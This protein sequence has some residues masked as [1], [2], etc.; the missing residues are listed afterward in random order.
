MYPTALGDMEGSTHDHR[1]AVWGPWCAATAGNR[2]QYRRGCLHGGPSASVLV[3]WSSSRQHLASRQS[4][5]GGGSTRWCSSRSRVRSRVALALSGSSGPWGV[6]LDGAWLCG[7]ARRYLRH[8][9]GT[10][11]PELAGLLIAD[12]C[13]AG[14]AA[15][16]VVTSEDL[17]GPP[18][19][20][21]TWPGV[22]LVEGQTPRAGGQVDRGSVVRIRFRHVGGDEGGVRAPR[23]SSP[24]LGALSAEQPPPER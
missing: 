3:T 10:V 13:E 5:C 21:L 23:S 7:A 4:S 16:L 9:T 1:S 20:V 18:L 2:C 17:D 24:D 8:V 6:R 14:Q 12:A 19:A 15:G 11:V 22:W